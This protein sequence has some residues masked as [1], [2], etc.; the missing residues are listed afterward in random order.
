MWLQGA[1][2]ERNAAQQLSQ[3]L[4]Y[5][6]YFKPAELQATRDDGREWFVIRLER[7]K[8]PGPGRIPGRSCEV[9]FGSRVSRAFLP[10]LG[11]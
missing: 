1:D 2:S 7:W 8:S 9:R 4:S 5:V 3:A 11:E 10:H 6:R